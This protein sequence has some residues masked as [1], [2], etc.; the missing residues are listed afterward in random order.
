MS[1]KPPTQ[2]L[3]R[4]GASA[5][6]PVRE[7]PH[8]RSAEAALLGSLIVDAGCAPEILDGLRPADFWFAEHRV[9]FEAVRDLYEANEGQG[10]D[11]L[12]VRQHLADQGLLERIGGGDEA[13]GT[14]YLQQVM[15]SVPSSANARYYLGIVQDK[16]RRRFVITTCQDLIEAAY[17]AS[18]PVASVL[19]EAQAQLFAITEQ[20][21]RSQE[22]SPLHDLVVRAYEDISRR[23]QGCLR[24][25]ASGF[26][27]LDE[28]TCGLR[29]GDMVLIAGRPSMGKT[30]LAMDIAT[31]VGVVQKKPVAV[32][33]LEMSRQQLAERALCSWSEVEGQKAQHGTLTQAEYDRL[34]EGMK[35]FQEGLILID[36]STGLTPFQL[37]AKARQM[38]RQYGVELVVIDYLQLMDAGSRAENRQQEITF[39]SRQVKAVAREL[40]VPVIALSQLNRGPESRDSHRPRMSDLRDSGSLEQ[41]ADLIVLLHR[42]DYYQRDNPAYLPTGTAEAIIAKQRKGPVGTVKLTFRPQFSKFVN[43]IEIPEAKLPRLPEPSSRDEEPF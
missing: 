34:V 4:R 43:H 9:L 31:H 5:P 37:R 24:G 16:T 38:R 6:G 32:F 35:A 3:A 21:R 25:L 22:P 2:A 7:I 15:D 19:N 13:A 26:Y 1:S 36:D 41:D 27:A 39:I 11:G 29:R 14:H 20:D 12:L 10:V 40:D 23:E 30:S 33:S 28:Y 17:N 42:E 18:E 8:S